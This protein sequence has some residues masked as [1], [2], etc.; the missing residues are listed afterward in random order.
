[1]RCS[2]T[3]CDP[4]AFRGRSNSGK[5]SE[6]AGGTWEP[7]MSQS[8]VFLHPSKTQGLDA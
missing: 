2:G 7:D 8:S 1:M 3:L 6:V 4:G 5:S